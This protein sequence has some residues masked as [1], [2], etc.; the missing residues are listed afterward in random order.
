VATR[1]RGKALW[2]REG[3][4]EWRMENENKKKARNELISEERK[5]CK[6]RG[7][8]HYVRARMCVEE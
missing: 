2:Y 6:M 7:W 1:E 8:S 3:N 5:E 4:E